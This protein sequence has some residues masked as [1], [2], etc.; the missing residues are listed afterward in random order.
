MVL[1][2][3]KKAELRKIIH[4]RKVNRVTVCNSCS[5]NLSDNHSPHH[6]YCRKCWKI[7]EANKDD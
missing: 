7:K 4:W 1:S 5:K 6:F 3:K 2:N